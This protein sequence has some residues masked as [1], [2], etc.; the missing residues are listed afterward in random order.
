MNRTVVASLASLIVLAVPRA[1][2]AVNVSVVSEAKPFPGIRVQTIHTTSPTTRVWAAF[3][4]LCQ[5]GHVRKHSV[6]RRR[7]A[8][9]QTCPVPWSCRTQRCQVPCI[10]SEDP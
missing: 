8:L 6:F 5:D 1:A 7:L 9:T 2:S 10:L 4:D 3:V